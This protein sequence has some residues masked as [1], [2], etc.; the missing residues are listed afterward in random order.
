MVCVQSI[1]N[2]FTWKQKLNKYVKK[3][4]NF[5]DFLEKL[6][7]KNGFFWQKWTCA[8][9]IHLR[10]GHIYNS[11][12]PYV[13]VS[14]TGRKCATCMIL[15]HPVHISE[16]QWKIAFFWKKCAVWAHIFFETILFH[17]HVYQAY[18]YILEISID[19][20]WSIVLLKCYFKSGLLILC[21]FDHVF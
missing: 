20:I 19:P 9:Q 15:W 13:Y 3:G 4:Q 10:H 21:D 8:N 18:F 16:T 1:K 2:L 17:R 11:W 14:V 7:K 6:T 5:S 12:G